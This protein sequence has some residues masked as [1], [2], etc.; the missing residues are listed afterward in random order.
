MSKTYCEKTKCQMF[1][2][3]KR[4]IR[5]DTIDSIIQAKKNK[6]FCVEDLCDESKNCND[7]EIRY[8]EQLKS[9]N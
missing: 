1:E 8:L 6:F 7:C 5:A 3:A 9:Q 4:Q 2:S